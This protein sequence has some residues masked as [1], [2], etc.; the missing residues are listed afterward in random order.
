MNRSLP[1]VAF[2]IPCF[3]EEEMLPITVTELSEMIMEYIT[4]EIIDPKSFVLFID[5]GSKDNTW[6]LISESQNDFIKGIKLS[7]NKGHQ[8][9]LLAGLEFVS[10]KC[11]CAI[12]LDADLQDDI[13][14]MEEMLSDF[15]DGKH[16]VY[17]IRKERTVD[18][19]FKKFTAELFYNLIRKMEVEI[20]FNHADFRLLSSVVLKELMGY[21]EVNLFLRGLFPVL[22]YTSSDVYYD[23]K[24]RLAGETKYPIGKM[25]ALAINGITS[26]SSTPLKYISY[27]GFTIFM[28]SILISMWV[29]YVVVVG[30]N[31]PGW[32][33][34]V[35]PIY[36]IGG[37]QLLSIGVLGEYI[38]KIYQESKQRPRY[39]IEEIKK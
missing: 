31:V 24:E 1:Q 38:G 28:I 22:G 36:F 29:L 33:S 6:K 7:R 39:H 15:K 5:D 37:V 21:K 18:S 27:M 19:F 17:G 12:S 34:T 16:I 9:A 13:S 14:V 4:R 11:D 3:N 30:D 23:R 26:F 10:D 8:H 35:L 2:V 20:K 32:A 25:L